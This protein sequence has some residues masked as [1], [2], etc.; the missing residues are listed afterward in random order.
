MQKDECL[1]RFVVYA[2]PAFMFLW[3]ASTIIRLVHVSKEKEAFE[4]IMSTESPTELCCGPA[5]DLASDVCETL[6]QAQYACSATLSS[7]YSR[8]LIAKKT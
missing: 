3:P 2:S 4:D 7:L 1:P 8:P 5:I 6:P